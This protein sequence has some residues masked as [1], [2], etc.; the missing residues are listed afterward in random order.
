MWLATGAMD[1]KRLKTIDL[2]CTFGRLWTQLWN[3]SLYL[4]YYLFLK[5]KVVSKIYSWRRQSFLKK[6]S[7]LP[8]I[9]HAVN[10]RSGPSPPRTT[11]LD[12]VCYVYISVCH[13][14]EKSEGTRGLFPFRRR[15]K[16]RACVT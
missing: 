15:H 6:I 16:V 11:L 12:L 8:T 5:Y 3:V 10:L 13:H 14:V 1:L 2:R 7:L 4:S 9:Q